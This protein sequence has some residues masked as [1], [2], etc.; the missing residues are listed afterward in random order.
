MLAN[1]FGDD[2]AEGYITT[3]GTESNLE[4]IWMG[5]ACLGDYRGSLALLKTKL[6][7]HSIDKAA[8]IMSIPTFDVSLDTTY[9]MSAAGLSRRFLRLYSK[10]FRKFLIVATAGYTATGTLDP[11]AE[12]A[13]EL[14]KFESKR[15]AATFLHVDAALGG[16]T[17]PFSDTPA[18]FDFRVKK[19]ETLAADMHKMGL[20]PYP[21]GVF[22]ARRGLNKKLGRYIEYAGSEDWMVSGSR[23]GASA[24]ACWAILNT[25]G[26]SGYTA[27]VKGSLAE[28]EWLIAELRELF[29]KLGVITHSA[30]NAFAAC[31]PLSPRGR[32]PGWL[33]QKYRL[34][35]ITLPH[36]SGSHGLVWYKLYI[37]PHATRSILRRVLEDFRAA[38]SGRS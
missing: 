24:A 10:G 37:M 35:P 7:H 29:P 4:A 3:G 32:L 27:V 2:R 6:T 36:K 13:E 30:V 38:A 15:A 34:H 14:E 5:R 23:S 8:S 11:I 28:K 1:L 22:L 31:F 17:I 19:V 9:G 25:L 21:A 16:F 26:R 33:E 12:I 18:S 20:A